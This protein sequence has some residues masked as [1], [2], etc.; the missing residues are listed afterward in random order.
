MALRSYADLFHRQPNGTGHSTEMALNNLSMSI[1]SLIQKTLERRKSV[2]DE[3]DL[4]RL[5]SVIE[6]VYYQQLFDRDAIANRAISVW[7]DECW[8]VQ[9]SVYEVEDA[10]VRTPF[11]S[12][13]IDLGRDFRQTHY[14]DESGSAILDLLHRAD[15]LSGIGRHGAILLGLDDGLDLREP[16]VYR[17]GQRLIFAR[18]LPE[19]LARVSRFEANRA[20]PRF[21]LPLEY[22]LTLNDARD[23]QGLGLD[24]GQHSVHWS[25][26]IH[27]TVDQV[28]SS[29][30]FALPA[31]EPVLNN[32][33]G[34]HKLYGCDP[35]AY[36]RGVVM[37]LFLE[38]ELGDVDVDLPALRDGFERMMNSLQ[39]WMV[40]KGLKANAIAP[41]VVDPLP[42]MEAQ[43]DAICIQKTV[44][45]R[46]FV[47]SERGELAS[48]QDQ[49]AWNKR[50]AGSQV[51]RRTPRLIC[52]FVDRLIDLGVLPM[53]TATRGRITSN[54]PGVASRPTGGGYSVW[55]PP[56][57][58]ASDTEKAAVALQWTQALAAYMTSGASA[59]M[60]LQPYL[61][62]VWGME[63][64]EAK[65]IVEEAE[66]EQAKQREQELMK[67][68]E[69]IDQGLVA[70]PTAPKV[71]P[72]APPAKGG[73]K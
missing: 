14:Q 63:E 33:L 60:P 70:D 53:P 52:P 56:I 40:L 26:V 8:Q 3:C 16:A 73:V 46:I 66:A 22:S 29:E 41:T 11:E 4:P 72:G 13:W 24:T 36:W 57:S 64:E 68:R 34:L 62:K 31:L 1:R 7:A 30:V 27:V 10:D 58:V 19:S 5:D 65:Q 43:L 47:G 35:E 44:P 39:Q 42:H 2:E 67:K 45:K 6:A 50:V 18:A 17:A 55:W 49:G 61:I 20:D 71:M 12:A 38:S 23:T 59:V 9:P 28:G 15:V 21:G 69:E 48:S 32:I 25:R 51:N 37:K 54:E